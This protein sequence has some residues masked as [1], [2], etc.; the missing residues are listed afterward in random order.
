MVGTVRRV[1][2]CVCVLI[3]V[4]LELTDQGEKA[5][6]VLNETFLKEARRE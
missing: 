4:L 5:V 1:Q 2:V 6:A 3:F